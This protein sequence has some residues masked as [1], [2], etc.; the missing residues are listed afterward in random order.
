MLRK[1]EY[2]VRLKRNVKGKNRV[3]SIVRTKYALKASE[4][5]LASISRSAICMGWHHSELRSE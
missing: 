2:F 1:R 4:A 3:L 5:L